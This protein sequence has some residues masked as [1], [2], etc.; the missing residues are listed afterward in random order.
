MLLYNF[1]IKM[2]LCMY[3]LWQSASPSVYLV[4]ISHPVFILH[5]I[6]HM[7]RFWWGKLRER[8]H[9]EDTGLGMMIILK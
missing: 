7:T 4:L 6:Y 8:G 1:H 5:I 3:L 2:L 9:L